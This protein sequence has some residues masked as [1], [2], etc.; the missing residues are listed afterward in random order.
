MP[1]RWKRRNH[2]VVATRSPCICV[3]VEYST[4]QVTEREREI[5]WERVN[6]RRKLNWLC[7]TLRKSRV[8]ILERE[9]FTRVFILER[10][11]TT[12]ASEQLALSRLSRRLSQTC[13]CVW[14]HACQCVYANAARG[15]TLR[16]ASPNVPI[17]NRQETPVHPTLW[18][19]RLCVIWDHYIPF[20][21]MGKEISPL[22]QK[23]RKT[24]IQ[25]KEV[26]NCWTK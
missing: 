4:W 13:E 23:R 25:V 9:L 14:N 15:F 5:E 16:R 3:T 8:F 24:H 19:C 11:W 21:F 6:T 22:I 2:I 17:S 20:P 1:L 7:F 10:E 26:L 18:V 12:R